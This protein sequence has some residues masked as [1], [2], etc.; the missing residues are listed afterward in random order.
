MRYLWVE[1]FDGGKSG[2]TELEKKLRNYF[3]LEN[4]MISKE[5]Q[6]TTLKSVLNFLEKK[7][8]W[9]LFDAILID[10]RFKVGEKDTDE[11]EIYTKYFSSFLTKE[12]YDYYTKK[13]NGDANSASSGILLYL[14]LIH[15]YN[16]NQKR[17][18]FLSGN[19]EEK[20]GAFPDIITMRKILEIAESKKLDEDE[21][22][23]FSLLNDALFNQ[24]KDLFKMDEETADERFLLPK[25]DDID[26]DNKESLFQ[27]RE[28]LRK[29]EIEM[30]IQSGVDETDIKLKYNSIKQEFEHIGLI[31]PQAFKKPEGVDSDDI[32]REFENWKINLMKNSYYKLRSCIV[33]IC[34]E[35]LEK[36]RDDTDSILDIP[37]TK[38]VKEENVK[39][40]MEHL[41]YNILAFFP[42]NVWLENDELLYSQIIGECVSLC[43]RIKKDAVQASTGAVLKITRNWIFHQGIKNIKVFDVVFIFHIL[44]HTFL[45]MNELQNIIELDK[46]MIESFC[47]SVE[48]SEETFQKVFHNCKENCRNKNKKAYDEFLKTATKEIKKEAERKYWK[49]KENNTLY[50]IISGIGNDFSPIKETVSMSL[51]YILFLG[52]SKEDSY[53]NCF[54]N[55]VVKLIEEEYTKD[56]KET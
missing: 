43:D 54:R 37:Y 24:Y 13:I 12:R 3:Q 38:L 11:D 6:H 31:M 17:I 56:I 1:D 14:A 10:I 23:E 8:N 19:V 26:W 44:I 28:D 51:L 55:Y 18:V 30:K 5:C 40:E 9:Y 21:K 33:P 53:N 4:S 52:N 47:D 39:I 20:E 15:R 29:L 16:Y 7:S 32:S 50:E 49:P 36:I 41:F 42:E 34:L 45:D 46:Q 2:R 35:I 27:I 25:E 22:N 48:L